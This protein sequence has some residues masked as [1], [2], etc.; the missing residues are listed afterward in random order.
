M[1]AQ[2]DREGR[3][4]LAGRPNVGKS[5]LFNRIS[6]ARRAIVTAAPGTTRDVL[7]HP[8]EWLG[9]PFELVD[10]GGVFGASADPLQDA[11]AVQGTRALEAASVDRPGD[12]R[13]GTAWFPRT[14]R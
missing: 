10:T 3:V 2:S 1:G 13:Q 7:R 5:T 11:V 14:S 8:T 4:V 6:G 9:T 12:R